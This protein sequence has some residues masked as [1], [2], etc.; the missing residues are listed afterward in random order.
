VTA[1][2]QWRYIDEVKDQNKIRDLDEV[3]YLDVAAIWDVTEWASLRAGVNNVTDE[4]P[5][6]IGSNIA[7]SSIY[8]AGN[9]FP[10]MYDANGRYWFVGASLTF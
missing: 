10:G 1:S 7:G 6:I 3:N 9:T 2:A 8:G 5:P 4:E